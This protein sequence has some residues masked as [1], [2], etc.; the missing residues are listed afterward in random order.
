MEKVK[1]TD[2]ED[3]V[4][5]QIRLPYENKVPNPSKIRLNNVITYINTYPEWWDLVIDRIKKCDFYFPDYI[6]HHL[7][8]LINTEI[9]SRR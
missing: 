9:N 2:L 5:T 7:V 6:H 4:K 3:F 1:I 8:N